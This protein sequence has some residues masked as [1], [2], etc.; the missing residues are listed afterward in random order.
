LELTV[1]LYAITCGHLTIPTAFLLAG[2]EGATRVPI[3]SY[4]I[5]HPRGRVVFDSGLHTNTQHNPAAHIGEVLAA[6]HQFDYGTGEDISARLTSIDVDPASVTHVVNSHLHFDHCGGNALLPNAT[7][8]VQR[9][10]LDAAKDGGDIK[11]YVTAD[12]DT[13]QPRQL[14]DG[15]H[16]LF[17]D[18]SVVLIPTYG[19]TPGHQSVRVQTENGEFVLC[20]DACYLKESLDTMTLPGI[21][22]DPDGAIAAFQL[23]R[24]LQGKGAT[25]MYGHDLEFWKTIP[26]AP[27]RLG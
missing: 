6:F 27:A 18:G 21:I 13:G 24:D 2:R 4:L 5:D 25:I 17:G 7:V 14:I 12:F 22:A 11:G 10:E 20:G 16:D 23:F 3:T 8:V 1:K 26:Q 19:H 15:Q 9:S